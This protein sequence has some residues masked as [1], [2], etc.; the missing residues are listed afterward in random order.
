MVILR[1]HL[2][3]GRTAEMKTLLMRDLTAAVASS[4]EIDPGAVRVMIVEVDHENWGI[5]GL[6]ATVARALTSRDSDEG[7]M[8]S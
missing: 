2:L 5:G 6:P 3:R 7:A 1:V 4:L 8:G